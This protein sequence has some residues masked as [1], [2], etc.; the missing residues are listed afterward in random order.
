VN[1]GRMQSVINQ[2][3]RETG[4]KISVSAKTM[5][6]VIQRD[7]IKI[8]VSEG[9]FLKYVFKTAD[10]VADTVIRTSWQV[11]RSPATTDF[12]LCDA[13]VVVVPPLGGRK[14]GFHVPGTV[15]YVPLSRGAC[16]RLSGPK[17]RALRYREVDSDTVALINQ[18]IAANSV[19]FVM[20]PSKLQLETIV[21]SSRCETPYATPRATFQRHAQDDD[22]SFEEVT[23]NPRNYF[24]LPDGRT[25]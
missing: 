12:V 17:R 9:P 13:P 21:T 3:E 19:R 15:T 2:Y 23:M 16:L 6:E 1:E 22:G 24:Y 20:G 14:V 8:A 4:D 25:P 11:L 10:L 18:N 7:G 5:V